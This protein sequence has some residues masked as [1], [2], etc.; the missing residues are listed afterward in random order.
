[1]SRGVVRSG[2]G[3]ST[4][5]DRETRLTTGPRVEAHLDGRVHHALHLICDAVVLRGKEAELGQ[6]RPRNRL[7]KALDEARALDDGGVRQ[8]QHPDESQREPGPCGGASRPPRHRAFPG[9]RERPEEHAVAGVL[10]SSSRATTRAPARVAVDGQRVGNVSHFIPK[11]ST[12]RLSGR[13]SG[14]HLT[15]P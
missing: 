3:F 10:R 1:M 4:V 14:R 2:V 13:H 7:A 8:E 15:P 12:F 6:E 5:G 11:I 9:G